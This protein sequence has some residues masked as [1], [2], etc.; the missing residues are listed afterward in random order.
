[1]AII[2]SAI[3]VAASVLIYTGD[4]DIQRILGH[5]DGDDGSGGY[6]D[7]ELTVNFIDVGQGDSILIQFPD[8]KNVLIDA[9]GSCDPDVLISY[10]HERSVVKI[11]GLFITH[12]HTDH[13]NFADE[14][15]RE[16]DVDR[17][18]M[19]DYAVNTVAYDELLEAIDEVDCVREQPS[20]G[21][22]FDFADGLQVLFYDGGADIPDDSSIVLRLDYGETSFPFAGDIGFGVES[23][24]VDEWDG[25]VDVD[26]LKVSHHGSEYSTSQSFLS[27][28]T[29]AISIISVGENNYGQPSPDTI[30]RL[31]AVGSEVFSTSEYGDITVMTDGGSDLP[32]ITWS[33]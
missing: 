25:L 27:F 16:F 24:L 9:G 4:L 23:W 8:G 18:Y 12:P 11:D 1:L 26:V 19:T 29:P 14:V 5:D 2:V 22:D 17:I 31:Y 3:V 32:V 30:G 28:V 10:L 7:G 20:I 33:T 15:L 13:I 6:V 21:M